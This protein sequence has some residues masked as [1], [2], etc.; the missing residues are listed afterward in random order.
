MASRAFAAVA[1][2]VLWAARE[3]D[4]SR[5]EVAMPITGNGNPFPKPTSQTYLFGQPK[6]NLAP[7][8]LHSIRYHIEEIEVGYD[9]EASEIITGSRVVWVGKLGRRI[10]EIITEQDNRGK[11]KT[12]TGVEKAVAWLR[13]YLTEHGPTPYK[14]VKEDANAHEITKTMLDRASVKLAVVKESSPGTKHQT[15]W[16]L[17]EGEATEITEMTAITESTEIT[18]TD[19]NARSSDL[20]DLS[21]ETRENGEITST[22]VRSL[23]DRERLWNEFDASGSVT[24]RTPYGERV[25]HKPKMSEAELRRLWDEW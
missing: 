3:D 10:E 7:K 14:I 4:L 1:R 22:E 24:D 20:S 2:G 25:G 8:V 11:G 15:Q 16:S 5:A 6:N 21:G 9:D 17:P 19:G 23:T 12:V 13:E 18:S